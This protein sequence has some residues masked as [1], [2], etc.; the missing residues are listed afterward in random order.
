M[1]Y[2]EDYRV[3]LTKLEKV[4]PIQ[5]K[6]YFIRVFNSGV[7][8]SEINKAG[9][10]RTQAKALE[11]TFVKDFNVNIEKGTCR[12]LFLMFMKFIKNNLDALIINERQLMELKELKEKEGKS[13]MLVP[14]FKSMMDF[15]I[16]SYITIF[17]ELSTPI[18]NAPKNP[19]ITFFKQIITRAGGFF[20]DPEKYPSK[21][22]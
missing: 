7:V 8:Q 18:I 13:I 19:K 10:N 14:S 2:F 22:Y 5:L 12:V 17:Y 21:I 1:I 15:V 16:I 9:I 20:V 6:D 3:S 11:K 4:A